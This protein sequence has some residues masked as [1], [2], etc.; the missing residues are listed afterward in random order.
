VTFAIHYRNC[1]EAGLRQHLL[2]RFAPL[3]LAANA[4]IFEGKQ[5]LE[6]APAGLPDKGDAVSRLLDEQEVE[7]LVYLGDD[8]SDLSVFSLVARRKA[9]GR[10][11]LGIAVIDSETDPEISAA[12]DMALAGVDAVEEFLD[13]LACRLAQEVPS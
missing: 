4:R 9:L 8:L 13:D 10:A 6:L 2:S 12:G 1:A 11:C 5:V 7:G 3:A